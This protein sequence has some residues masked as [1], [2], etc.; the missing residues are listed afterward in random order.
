M[1]V[2]VLIDIGKFVDPSRL[3]I[4]NCIY[5]QRNT[6][7]ESCSHEFDISVIAIYDYDYKLTFLIIGLLWFR[8]FPYHDTL[9]PPCWHFLNQSIW[10]Q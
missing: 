8:F 2:A 3:R 7:A 4:I 1:F 6:H 10:H 5:L 9:N